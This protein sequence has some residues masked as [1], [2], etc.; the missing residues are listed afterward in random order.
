MR[1]ERPMG[2]WTI[3]GGKNIRLFFDEMAR[4]RNFDPL[5]PTNWYRIVLNDVLQEVCRERGKTGE[6][7]KCLFFDEM[8]RKRNMDPL[9]CLNTGRGIRKER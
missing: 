8:A 7:E 3:D 2:H 6:N 1:K 4:K 9:P 5:V